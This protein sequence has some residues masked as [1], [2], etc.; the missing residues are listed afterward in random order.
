MADSGIDQVVFNELL[1]SMGTDFTR[2]LVN[3]FL[4]D[5]PRLIA[6]LQPALTAGDQTRF[7]AT[8]AQA[9]PEGDPVYFRRA[10]HFLTSNAA[11][12]GATALSALA[13]ELEF[14]ARE[15]RLVEVGD[16]IDR[17]E[18][19]FAQAAGELKGLCG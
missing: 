17:L 8:L 15:N 5:A 2:D 4:E 1:E 13:K 11:T 12:F 19:L 14:M 9:L 16:R 7:F 10:A 3:T 18:T 6:Q